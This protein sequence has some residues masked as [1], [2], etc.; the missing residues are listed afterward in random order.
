MS[1]CPIRATLTP[2]LLKGAVAMAMLVG[3]KMLYSREV[4]GRYDILIYIRHV[5]G[6]DGGGGDCA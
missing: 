2:V 1:P 6:G 3:S 5:G 4:P